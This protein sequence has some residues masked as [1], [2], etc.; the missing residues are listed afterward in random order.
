MKRIGL[1]GGMSWESSA[2][3]YRILNQ[4][5]NK[6]L[7]GHHSCECVMFSIDFE[8]F[9][10]FQ[11]EDNWQGVTDM[12]V[13][14]AQILEASGAE[15]IALCANTAHKMAPEVCAATH[16]PLVHIVDVTAEAI[17]KQNIKRIGLIGTKFT[18]EEAFYKNWLIEKHGLEVVVPDSKEIQTIHKVIFEELVFGVVNDKSKQAYLQIMQHLIER[19]AEG[20]I[21]GCTEIPH[22]ISQLDCAYPIFDTTTLHAEK[23]VELSLQ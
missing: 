9:Q 23:I 7:G 22:L 21:L 5:I 15:L 1:I 14:A 18:M 3:Y 8:K 10:Q 11:H 19:G 2:E 13:N 16:I 12:L 17:K 4:T 20:V 6:R